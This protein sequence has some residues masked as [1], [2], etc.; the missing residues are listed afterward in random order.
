MELLDLGGYPEI[1][2]DGIAAVQILGV[3]AR[4]LYFNFQR[5]ASGLYTRQVV[6]SLIRPVKSFEEGAPVIWQAIANEKP[7]I[8]VPQ[9]H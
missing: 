6:A 2:V 9:T 5:A 1:Y 4:T 7:P 8:I 3:C